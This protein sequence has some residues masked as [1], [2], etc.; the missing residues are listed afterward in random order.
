[1]K[2][3]ASSGEI[4]NAYGPEGGVD[5]FAAAGYDA[6]DFSFGSVKFATDFSE[7]NFRN[8]R[9]YAEERDLVFN[10]AHAPF[11]SSCADEEL[12]KRRFEE[13]V[14]CIKNASYLGV[15]NIVVHPCQHLTYNDEGVPEK[16]FEMNMDFYN[17]LKPYSEEYG[18][19][20]AIENMWQSVREKILHSTCSRPDE[21]IR[22]IDELN[23]D[24]FV[25]C[26]DIGHA[27]LVC[28]KPDEFIRKLGNKR[29]KALHVHDVDGIHDLHTLP[30]FGIID[31][32][33]V[34]KALAEIE[35]EGDLTFEASYFMPGKPVELY[36]AYGKLMTD[37][38][39]YLIKKIE[40]Y[41]K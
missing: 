28:E 36:P 38:G 14:Q 20:I 39:R 6:I 8:L 40:S 31:W 32:D 10:Q 21:F 5:F 9:K 27:M 34:A 22:Y 1:M 17:S 30:Y 24:C 4:F 29:L 16:L 2:L 25:A 19:R 12:T 35:Y 3:S 26:L 18:V 15:R 13:I 41:K 11:P 7:R 33:S 37:T 23:S